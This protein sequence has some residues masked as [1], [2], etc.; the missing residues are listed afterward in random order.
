MDTWFGNAPVYMQTM[1]AT[2]QVPE[3]CCRA[4]LQELFADQ[5]PLWCRLGS[6]K[7]L[8]PKRQGVSQMYCFL[9]PPHSVLMTFIRTRSI[10]RKGVNS[11]Q[12][13]LQGNNEGNWC[14][15]QRRTPGK[16]LHHPAL[17]WLTLRLQCNPQ[18]V[19]GGEG[20]Q[21]ICIVQRAERNVRARCR[22]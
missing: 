16:A 5:A 6:S 21:G 1:Q 4:G 3:L 19:M 14:P 15:W 8:V 9:S 11:K 22:L 13:K 10:E 20:W 12:D 2:L 17:G 7:A 18:E